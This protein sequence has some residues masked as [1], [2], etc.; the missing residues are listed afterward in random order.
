MGG[1]NVQF[2]S[3]LTLAMDGGEWSDSCPRYCN[4]ER[5][6]ERE[7]EKNYVSC[8]LKARWPPEPVWTLQRKVSCPCWESIHDSS[9][10][11]SMV[12]SL[13]SQYAC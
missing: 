10:V 2:L 5:E 3:F 8:A 6:R 11:Q 13:Y 1:V 7:R 9:V 4:V 12:W